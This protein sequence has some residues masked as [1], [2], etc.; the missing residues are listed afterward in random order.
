VLHETLFPV[1]GVRLLRAAQSI[2]RE[3]GAPPDAESPSTFEK[4]MPC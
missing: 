4:E 2:S 1:L 3:L